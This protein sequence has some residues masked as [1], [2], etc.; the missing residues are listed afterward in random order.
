MKHIGILLIAVFLLQ[1]CISKKKTT[2]S[3]KK[4][5][6]VVKTTKASKSK[7][8]SGEKTKE[9]KE[10]LSFAII[11]TTSVEEYLEVY[12]AIAQEE[13]RKYGIPASITLAQGILESGYGMG[14][15]TLK[16]N[17]HFGIKCHNSWEGA[18]AYHDDDEKGECFR[19]YNHPKLSFRD[20][21]LFLSGR[22]RYAFLF[23]LRRDDY[24]AWAK[25]LKKAGYATD[26]KYPQKLISFI[27]RYNLQEYDKAVIKGGLTVRPEPKEYDYKS[28]IVQKGDTLYSISRTYFMSVDE[29]KK[30][31]NI[32][33]STIAVGQRLK[34]KSR[35]VK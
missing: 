9:L 24:K 20:H 5:K 22:A 2:Y 13:M 19:K 33:S 25:G 34:I 1:G 8:V 15:L 3:K 32:R 18:V 30:L 26:N 31:N 21:S 11:E 27:E 12:G 35:R 6:E 28:Y 14:K 16:T 17:N 29:I 23:D 10:S 4:S 7:T